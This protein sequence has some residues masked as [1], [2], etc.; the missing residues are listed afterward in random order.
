[1][2]GESR[3]HWWPDWLCRA[4]GGLDAGVWAAV[5]L[6]L[7]FALLGVLLDRFWWACFNVSAW[8]L[9]G[10]RVFSMGLS[11]A[12]VAGIS[13]LILIYGGLGLFMG[14]WFRP[15]SGLGLLARAMILALAW[16]FFAD[17]WF[18]H[19]LSPY[20]ASYFQARLVLPGHLL[21]ALFLLRYRRRYE[22]VKRVFGEPPPVP[23]PSP[24]PAAPLA[25]EFV[26]PLQEEEKPAE[27]G[28]PGVPGE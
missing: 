10:D 25:E 16:H 18:W 2:T 12:T 9:F 21:W 14:L 6:L 5:P 19:W 13:L 24:E 8:P 20:S 27:G 28:P 7:W 26:G 22:T 15:D 11:W 1:M 3:G 4:M 17:R 23:E